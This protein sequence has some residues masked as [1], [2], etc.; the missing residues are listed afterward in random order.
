MSDQNWILIEDKRPPIGEKVLV[1]EE[2]EEISIASYEGIKSKTCWQNGEEREEK[3]HCWYYYPFCNVTSIDPVAWM[4]L[5]EKYIKKEKPILYSIIFKQGCVVRA[6]SEKEAINKAYEIANY[7][8]KNIYEDKTSD[9]SEFL[10][11]DSVNAG[12]KS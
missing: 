2:C 6:S 4:P 12:L 3:Y 11:V 8:L 7:H 5:P 10:I 9:I 1:Q